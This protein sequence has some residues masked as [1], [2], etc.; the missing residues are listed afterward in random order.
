MSDKVI[1]ACHKLKAHLN[2]TKVLSNRELV[3]LHN[4]RKRNILGICGKYMVLFISILVSFGFDFHPC[5]GFHWWKGT[6]LIIKYFWDTF[7]V[8]EI[9]VLQFFN[10]YNLNHIFTVQGPENVKIWI[11]AFVCV[12]VFFCCC[13]FSLFFCISEAV[14]S[15]H[16]LP[17][18]SISQQTWWHTDLATE[19]SNSQ[20]S[21]VLPRPQI[22]YFLITPPL[23]LH[24]FKP[25]VFGSP[26]VCKEL[27][28]LF[29]FF[30]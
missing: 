25:F 10:P 29:L 22:I 23:W 19:D 6:W 11:Y 5:L 26:S 27:L 8:F 28:C 12:H 1:S 18:D 3:S 20:H 16:S 17:P 14:T 13:F 7:A 9:A 2:G 21:P 30:N 15:T 4:L 24:L